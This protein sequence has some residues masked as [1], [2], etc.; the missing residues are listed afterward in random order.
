MR[1]QKVLPKSQAKVKP[2][3]SKTK[4]RKDAIHRP[5]SSLGLSG[6]LLALCKA[7]N[8]DKTVRTQSKKKMRKRHKRFSRRKRP[9]SSLGIAKRH[10]HVV[11]TSA[12]DSNKMKNCVRKRNKSDSNPMPTDSK[13]TVPPKAP[14]SPPL[15]APLGNITAVAQP[16]AMPPPSDGKHQ[17]RKAH[18]SRKAM[19][20]RQR[21]AAERA[22]AYTAARK[23]EN[24]LKFLKSAVTSSTFSYRNIQSMEVTCGAGGLKGRKLMGH[25]D[26]SNAQTT[27][28]Y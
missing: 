17:I 3:A 15:R 7:R 23:K 5:A 6:P 2:E 10:K 28:Q 26:G 27:N 12:P 20:R 9:E 14:N 22:A 1:T 13:P 25:I 8:V 16:V 18:R 21:I 24:E 11:V 19:I 4:K